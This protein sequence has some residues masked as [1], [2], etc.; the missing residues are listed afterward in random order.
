MINGQYDRKKSRRPSLDDPK[1]AELLRG[2]VE[3]L[4]DFRLHVR[5]AQVHQLDG[6]RGWLEWLQQANQPSRSKVVE[7]L[8]G[9]HTDDS[10]SAARR[11][12]LRIDIVHQQAR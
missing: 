1:P 6:Q 10:L 12:E 5:P 3:K 4:S 8:I 7:H 11:C 9:Q 2:E